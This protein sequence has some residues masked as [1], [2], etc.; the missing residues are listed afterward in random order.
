MIMVSTAGVSIEFGPTLAKNCSRCIVSGFLIV[1][2]HLP[3][4]KRQVFIDLD[5]EARPELICLSES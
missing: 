1:E 5:I 4:D 3:D 2:G